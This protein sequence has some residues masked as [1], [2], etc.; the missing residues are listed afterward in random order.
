MLVTKRSRCPR[1]AQ[2]GVLLVLLSVPDVPVAFAQDITKLV[3]FGDSLSDP[4]N[5]F[6]AFGTIAQQ[7]FMPLPDPPYAIGGD[8]FSTG[9]TWAEQ[10]AGKLHLPTSGSPALRTPGVFTNYAVGR[11]RARAGAP[12][13]P[14]YDLSTQVGLFLSDFGGQAPSDSLY[15]V[16]IGAN[17]LE[18]ALNA[19]A[20]DPSAATSGAIIQAAITAVAGNIYTLWSFGSRTFLIPNVPNLALTPAVRALGP[21][22]QGVATQLTA[23]YNGA[24]DQVLSDLQ[25]RLGIN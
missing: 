9:A 15:V 16:W 23:A 12:V 20:S 1:W 14:Q 3:F 24:L 6:L 19:L 18:D 5:D 2:V 4:G 8:H 11:A 7:P 13:F 25:A 21:A 17:D 10:L 22:A